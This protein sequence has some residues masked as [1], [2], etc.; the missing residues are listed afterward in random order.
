MRRLI[1]LLLFLFSPLA[2]SQIP[3]EPTNRWELIAE[4]GG[5]KYFL[6]K[7]TL[8]NQGPDVSNS[9]YILWVKEEV[10]E[11]L[12]LKPTLHSLSCQKR[13]FDNHYIEPESIQEKFYYYICQNLTEKQKQLL[14]KFKNTK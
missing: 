8:K 5:R 7:E 4:K 3:I 11:D 9:N 6:D 12:T 1:L 14:N 13:M 10:Q 2:F